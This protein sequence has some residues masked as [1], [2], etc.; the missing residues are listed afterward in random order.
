GLEVKPLHKIAVDR[1]SAAEIGRP[2]KESHLSPAGLNGKLNASF[3]GE[4]RCPRPRRQNDGLASVM[5]FVGVDA[6]DPVTIQ[7]QSLDFNALTYIR[8]VSAGC[9]GERGHHL[10]SLDV[11]R[12]RLVSGQLV[13]RQASIRIEI[14]HL[15]RR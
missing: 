3:T 7:Y 4:P 13:F 11:A 12:F 2:A 10:Y 14:R 15:L 9:I 5:P 1:T 6:G 8:A